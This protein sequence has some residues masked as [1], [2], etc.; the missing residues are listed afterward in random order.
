MNN[1]E[2]DLSLDSY[3]TKE[4]IFNTLENDLNKNQKFLNFL[5]LN[6]ENFSKS[7]QSELNEFISICKFNQKI[8]TT[9]EKEGMIFL[10]EQKKIENSYVFNE[11][12]IFLN[13]IEEMK[14]KLNVIKEKINEN[15]EI[16]R[17][18][19][20]PININ[21]ENMNI[22]IVCKNIEKILDD[23]NISEEN[24]LEIKN[25]ELSRLRKFKN[26]ICELYELNI[27][28]K[29]QKEKLGNKMKTYCNLPSDIKKIKEM[30]KQKREEYDQL[31][32]T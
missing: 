2:Y 25:E 22:E 11:L 24:R 31:N 26:E 17:M 20:D 16:K 29:E 21:K 30:I 6:H 18:K 8:F 1:G 14:L 7:L 15:A 32:I 5:S 23:R 10:P 13:E 28:L 9:L 12:Q 4:I 3:K 19:E 27:K